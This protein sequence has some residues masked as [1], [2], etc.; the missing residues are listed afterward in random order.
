MTF[1]DQAC[2][3]SQQS[4]EKYLKAR[5]LAAE[6]AESRQ[7]HRALPKKS[8]LVTMPLAV[9]RPHTQG[10]RIKIAVILEACPAL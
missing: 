7:A 5:L 3:H 8:A 2:F 6:I 4:A 9:Q 1:H 10:N